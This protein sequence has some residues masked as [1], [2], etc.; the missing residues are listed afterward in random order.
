ME[1]NAF[2]TLLKMD[3]K[4]LKKTCLFYLINKNYDVK[5]GDGYVYGEGDIPVMLI[6]HLDTV[7]KTQPEE[8]YF[9][10]KETTLW[11]PQGIGGDDRC[12]VYSIMEILKTHKPH[13]LFV[14]DEEIGSV[15]TRKA[16]NKL[17]MPDVMFLIELDR[18]G[19]KDCVFYDCNNKDFKNYIS[20]FGFEENYGTFTDIVVL[21]QRWKIASVNLSIG[22]NREHTLAET[23]NIK[24]MQKTIDKVKNILDDV[25]IEPEYYE[26]MPY[27]YKYSK[28][29]DEPYLPEEKEEEIIDEI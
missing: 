19:T 14:E 24:A 12:G 27:E 5:T 8:I 15:G 13:V 7:H 2:K 6:A 3:Q 21:S 28:I 22:Y 11:S 18:R 17:I 20:S 29:E 26:Y 9:D 10:E 25:V 16:I 23:I 1:L 4:N